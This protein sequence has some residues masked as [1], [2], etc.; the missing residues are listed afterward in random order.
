MKRRKKRK[1]DSCADPGKCNIH[2]EEELCLY[3]M[4]CQDLLCF[5]CAGNSSHSRHRVE[6][7]DVAQQQIQSQINNNL[8][9]VKDKREKLAN[10]VGKVTTQAQQLPKVSFVTI[11]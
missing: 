5:S 4:D 6:A 3:C 8:E 7:L 11:N 2:K 9:S 1:I 10:F